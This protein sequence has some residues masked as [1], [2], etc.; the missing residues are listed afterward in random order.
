MKQPVV[1]FVRLIVAGV[2]F[3]AGSHKLVDAPAF[4]EAIGRYQL[5]PDWGNLLLASILPTL[6][7]VVAIAL[8]LPRWW[9][10]A[11]LLSIVLNSMFAVALLSAMIRGLSIDCG[12]FGSTAGMWSTLAAALLRATGLLGMSLYLFLSEQSCRE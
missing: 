1:L 12:C 5:L 2:F 8:L 4:A 7:I 11:S 6:E 10:A 3:Y 9:R